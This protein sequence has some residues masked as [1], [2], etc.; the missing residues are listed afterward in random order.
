MNLKE[1]ELKVKYNEN[2]SLK[3]IALVDKFL[4]NETLD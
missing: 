4:V 2:F 1:K 3:L